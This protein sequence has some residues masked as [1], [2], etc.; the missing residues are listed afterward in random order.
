MQLW[1]ETSGLIR[2]Y[3]ASVSAAP[4]RGCDLILTVVSNL[5]CCCL[6][7]FSSLAHLALWLLF[8]IVSLLRSL[9][10]MGAVGRH[11]YQTELILLK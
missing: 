5:Y 3:D 11:R 1:E 2:P 6:I 9:I 8:Y 7:I 10:F 4:R